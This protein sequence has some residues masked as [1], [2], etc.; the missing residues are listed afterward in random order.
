MNK[1]IA[2]AIINQFPVYAENAVHIIEQL[3]VMC[4]NVLKSNDS[5]QMEVIYAYKIVLDSL[6][7]NVKKMIYLQKNVNNI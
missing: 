1:D 4:N 7:E 3:N 2:I 5:S 6:S